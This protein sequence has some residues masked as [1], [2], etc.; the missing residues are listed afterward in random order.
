MSDAQQYYEG[1]F[2]QL[3]EKLIRILG[4]PTVDRLIERSVVEIAGAH[5]SVAGL[6]IEDGELEFDG[7]R[8]D[9]LDATDAKV[10]DTFTALTGVLLLLVARLLGREIALR[11]TEDLTVGELL[12]SRLIGIQ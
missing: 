5:P 4:M 10:R 6:K 11:L 8:S 7:L 3:R 12:E 9:L 2:N 1:E